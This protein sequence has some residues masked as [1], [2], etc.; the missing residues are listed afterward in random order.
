MEKK[1]NSQLFRSKSLERISSPEELND[2][3]R[4]ANP[5]VWMILIAV[6]IL[7][8][9]VLVWAVFG[10]VSTT[11]KGVCVASE[12]AAS[13]YISE[14]DI[15]KVQ[16]GMEVTLA[17]GTKSTVS[18]FGSEAFEADNALTDYAMHLAEFKE[19][20]WVHPLL[21]EGDV[22]GGIQSATVT[23]SSIHPIKFIFN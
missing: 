20:Q 11:V 4:V 9:G 3:V 21:L 6:V 12:G 22:P 17:D 19:G 14:S 18:A 5:G 1:D 10:N 7:L 16:L 23:I 15:S 13:I 8:A 2:Y